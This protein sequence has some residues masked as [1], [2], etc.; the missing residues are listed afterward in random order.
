MGATRLARGTLEARI[1]EATIVGALDSEV[2][3]ESAPCEPASPILVAA[4]VSCASCFGEVTSLLS[5]A[6]RI[7]LRRATCYLLLVPYPLSIN[8]TAQLA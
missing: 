3:S 1:R 4:H 5:L 8:L 7:A 6:L 2:S